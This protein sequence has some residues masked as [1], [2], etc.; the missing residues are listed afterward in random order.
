[1]ATR[2]SRARRAPLE[3]G[4]SPGERS[5][6]PDVAA[7][8]TL[9]RRYQDLAFATAYARLGD[10]QLAEDAAQDAFLTAWRQLTQL[11]ESA[12]FPIWLRS[13]V[14]R[15]CARVRRGKARRLLALALTSQ[16]PERADSR[17]D[18][19]QVLLLRERERALVEPVN[20]LPARLRDVVTLY[21]I[22]DCPLH[23]IAALLQ[24]R[25]GTIKKRLHDARAQL[26]ARLAREDFE[27][28]EK[29]MQ[30]TRPSRDD[31]IRRAGHRRACGCVAR[32]RAWHKHSAAS[33]PLTGQRTGAA[34]D[35]ERPTAATAPR[36]RTRPL[37]DRA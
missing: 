5:G 17:P 1:M 37:G 26:R 29:R 7:F 16:L 4:Q 22:A 2:A 31:Q 20:A 25:E 21:Y 13:I 27:M 18:P 10:R 6:Q 32:R 8:E 33:R 3:K 35:L 30:H 12:A 11:R 15:Q 14:H 34:P 23:E 28:T 19:E 24:L 9:V 36:G